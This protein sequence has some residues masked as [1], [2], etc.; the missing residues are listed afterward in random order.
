MYI[1]INGILYAIFWGWMYLLALSIVFW[2]IGDIFSG[3]PRKNEDDPIIREMK[4]LSR[5]QQLE[6]IKMFGYEKAKSFYKPEGWLIKEDEV[7]SESDALSGNDKISYARDVKKVIVNLVEIESY[8]SEAEFLSLGVKLLRELN[9]YVKQIA[10]L[11]PEKRNWFK[12]EA[13]LGSHLVRL[14][15]LLFVVCEQLDLRRLE[16]SYLLTRVISET[17]INM[18]FILNNN[19]DRTVLSY[20]AQSLK[21]EN[22]FKDIINTNIN[23][24]GH[25]LPIEDRMLASIN[26]NFKQ[27]SMTSAQITELSKAWLKKD[28]KKYSTYQRVIDLGFND[29]LY[30]VLFTLP[31]HSIHADWKDALSYHLDAYQDGTFGPSLDWTEPKFQAIEGI[32]RFTCVG[33]NK[34]IAY[35]SKNQDTIITGKIVD[36]SQRIDAVGKAHEKFLQSKINK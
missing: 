8:T 29:L 17:I 2:F 28:G 21:A 1:D 34:Y 25:H 5:K 35:L 10:E 23:K 27:S 9:D 12:S 19:N 4:E 13:V 6:Y 20:I 15:K 7:E 18:I 14:H 11:V 33:L 22:E 3:R 16:I 26:A 36:I 30:M 31:S 24:R 32:S